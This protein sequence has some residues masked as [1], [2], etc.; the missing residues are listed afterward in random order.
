MALQQQV[1][2][3][4]DYSESPHYSGLSI[5]KHGTFMFEIRVYLKK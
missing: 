5:V 3:V 4:H 1:Y 2:S